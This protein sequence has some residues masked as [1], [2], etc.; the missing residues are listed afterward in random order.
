MSFTSIKTNVGCTGTF[1]CPVGL[2]QWYETCTLHNVYL[3]M[4]Y[5]MVAFQELFAHNTEKFLPNFQMLYRTHTSI[6]CNDL[7]SFVWTSMYIF[8]H[9]W[10]QFWVIIRLCFLTPLL[11]HGND[12]VTMTCW[13]LLFTM[14]FHKCQLL[15][16][17]VYIRAY[18]GM[19]CVRLYQCTGVSMSN[20]V[21]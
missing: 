17:L 11:S 13:P 20:S 6:Y 15:E 18:I 9:V 7:C 3:R 2:R 12:E 8:I 14:V 21:Y 10:F 5:A 16:G 1:Q 19:H 4:L